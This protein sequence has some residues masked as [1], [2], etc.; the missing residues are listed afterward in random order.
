MAT[1]VPVAGDESKFQHSKHINFWRRCLKT[2]LPHQYTSNDANRMT[3]AFFILSALDLL[4]NL[5]AALSAE[6]RQG[7]IEWVY[8]CQLPEG[9]FRAFPGADFGSQRNDENK[10]WDP[11]HIPATFFA[12][13]VLALLGDDLQRV[14]RR[15]ILIWLNRMQR[16]DG[17]FGETLREDGRIEGGNDTRFG[18][19]STGIRWILRGNVEGSVDGVPDINVDKFVECIRN[20]ET[21]DGGISETKF[22]EAHAGFT[23]CAVSALSF[24]DR[25]PLHEKA[26]PQPD[27]Y[28]HGISNL[29]LTLHWLASRQTLTLDEEDTID[30]FADE[31]D[32]AATC[33]D[34][35][36]FVKL[37]SYPSKAGELSF[38][39]QPTSHFELQ[40]VGINGRANKI[41]DTCYAYWVCVPLKVLDHLEL[42]DQ[43]P[44]RRWL[45]DKTQHLVGG[46]GKLPGDA[47]DIYHAYLGL[48]VLAM[49]GEPGLKD[50]DAALCM[51][52]DAKRY[53]ESLLWRREI[54][55]NEEVSK[56]GERAI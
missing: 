40:W 13:L 51:S 17:S 3:F 49:F 11:A 36:S 22:H 35:R 26:S 50:F 5:Q 46:F 24:I 9:G 53:I 27:D 4:G 18:Y 38:K 39:W 6:E 7:H 43:R 20:S 41:A 2:F 12:L 47:P 14:K 30:K 1:V 15:E 28:L 45:L 21:Y 8:H 32:S 34:S 19:M 48:A 25:L 54:V 42:V 29:P 44:I 10:I 23:S 31:T 37:R 56:E 16:P 33:H 55:G 52:N